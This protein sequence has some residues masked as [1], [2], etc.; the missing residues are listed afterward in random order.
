MFVYP[1]TVKKFASTTD[2]SDVLNAT[3]PISEARLVSVVRCGL[4]VLYYW[5]V[6]S[7]LYNPETFG[8]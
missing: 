1:H 3:K 2:D 4:E 6:P 5:E 7:D 8:Q